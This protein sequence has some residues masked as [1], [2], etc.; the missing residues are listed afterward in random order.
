MSCGFSP[1]EL[2]KQYGYTSF[3]CG[4]G[5]Q[6]I[7]DTYTTLS[8]VFTQQKPKV[9]ILDADDFFT[10]AGHTD[11]TDGFLSGV[12]G[13]LIPLFEYHNRWKTPINLINPKI[14]VSTN[15]NK[16][17]NLDGTVKPFTGNPGANKSEAKIDSLTSIQLDMIYNLCKKNGAQLLI[18]FIPHAVSWN[19][20]KHNEIDKYA[21]SR[22][23]NFLDLNVKNPG[24]SFDWKAYT[25]DAGV[26]LNYWGA[27]VVTQY[28][29]EYLHNNYS[30]PDRSKDKAYQAWDSDYLKYDKQVKSLQA[31]K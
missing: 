25:K 3:N 13:R 29:G 31:K 12:L 15:S 22:G 1:M 5:A 17:Y 10:R 24:F 7:F 19:Q 21:S 20:A 18:V 23:I 8:H 14:S 28:I 4:V 27:K 26:H 9:V 6:I 16:G 11:T 30:I 2:W